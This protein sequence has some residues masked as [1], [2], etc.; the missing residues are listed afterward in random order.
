MPWYRYWSF[1][2]KNYNP[3]WDFCTLMIQIPKVKQGMEGERLQPSD[4]I[5]GTKISPHQSDGCHLLLLQ[6]N[7]PQCTSSKLTSKEESLLISKGTLKFS[8]TWGIRIASRHREN[9]AVELLCIMIMR[10]RRRV[11]RSETQS[12]AIDMKFFV[13]W[14]SCMIW[15]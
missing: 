1:H 3:W 14:H 2:A 4:K 13:I 11:L 9:G 8:D 6:K 5:H 12:P 10:Q 15:H 7:D